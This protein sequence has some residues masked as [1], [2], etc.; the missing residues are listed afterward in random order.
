MENYRY[1]YV[2][3][4]GFRLIDYENP[5]VQQIM[6]AMEVYEIQ[7]NK[8][9]LNKSGYISLPVSMSNRE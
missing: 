4:T 8:V 3:L 1:N 9:M 6:K 2:N 5:Y 7:T